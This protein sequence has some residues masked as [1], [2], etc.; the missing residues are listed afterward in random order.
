MTVGELLAFID[1]AERKDTPENITL[2][3]KANGN[4]AASSASNLLNGLPEDISNA[5]VIRFTSATHEMPYEG[6]MNIWYNL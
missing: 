4:F 6:S 1:E 2:Y 3:N 5:K